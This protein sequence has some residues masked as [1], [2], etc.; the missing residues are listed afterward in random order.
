MQDLNIFW[1]TISPK[2]KDNKY[3]QVTQI[4]AVSL[5]FG[6]WGSIAS[7]VASDANLASP[8]PLRAGEHFFSFFISPLLYPVR[9][10]E[11]DDDEQYSGNDV[12]EEENNEDLD[13]HEH[14]GIEDGII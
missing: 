8:T 2:N 12:N 11:R 13:E 9:A 3:R 1:Q 6:R 4:A 7:W 10:G 14:W 5:D